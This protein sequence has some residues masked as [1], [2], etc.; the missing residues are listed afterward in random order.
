MKKIILIAAIT[1]GALAYFGY[2][3]TG[4]VKT[5]LGTVTDKVKTAAAE[6]VDVDALKE[7]VAAALKS[8]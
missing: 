1:I 3:D 2:L 6:H 5:G 4:K 8:Q 7:Q